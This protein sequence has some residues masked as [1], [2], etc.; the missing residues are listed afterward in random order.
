M[1]RWVTLRCRLAGM[2][3]SVMTS[4]ALMPSDADMEAATAGV[5]VAVTARIA[6]QGMWLR[7]S[8]PARK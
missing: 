6:W 5:A 7:T 3:A 1:G 8:R 2:V 4:A